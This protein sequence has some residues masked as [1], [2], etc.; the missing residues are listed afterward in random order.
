MT[1]EEGRTDG[2]GVPEEELGEFE[3]KLLNRFGKII[4]SNRYEEIMF[5]REAFLNP[6]LGKKVEHLR[7][8]VPESIIERRKLLLDE[9]ELVASCT[10][11]TMAMTSGG[12]WGG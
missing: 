6:R 9:A 1:T 12:E 11:A 5:K 10:D 7:M 8:D 2:D 4:P 3:E